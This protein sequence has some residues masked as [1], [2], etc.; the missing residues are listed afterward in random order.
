MSILIGALRDPIAIL[1]FACVIIYVTLLGKWM[2]NEVGR[3]FAIGYLVLVSGSTVWVLLAP[4]PDEAML[5]PVGE[6]V[7]KLALVTSEFALV[8]LAAFS[9]SRALLGGTRLTNF[10]PILG[11][12]ALGGASLLSALLANSPTFPR[13]A[14]VLPIIVIG[15]LLAGHQS[16]HVPVSLFIS[17][18]GGIMWA[19]LALAVIAPQW[20]FRGMTST[21]VAAFM[22]RL[23]GVT[24]HPNSLGGLAALALAI[25]LWPSVSGRV[26]CLV[27]PPTLAVLYL[28]ESKTAWVAAITAVLLSWVFRNS[29]SHRASFKSALLIVIVGMLGTLGILSIDAGI[30]SI[31]PKA[32]ESIT[33]LTGRTALWAT[34]LDLWLERPVLGYG[35][36]AWSESWRAQYGYTF[37]GQAHNQF[38]QALVQTGL[39]GLLV[40]VFY[41]AVLGVAAIRTATATNG[42]TLSIYAVLLLRCLTEAP[43]RF[44]AVDHSFLLHASVFLLIT[45][46]QVSTPLHLPAQKRTRRR[47]NDTAKVTAALSGCSLTTPR[48]ISTIAT[49]TPAGT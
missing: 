18:L 7:W 5:F 44:S 16:K 40:N 28:S 1:L 26:R 8:A 6:E 39:V 27:L 2:L 37:A 14:V 35:Q 13:S 31:D 12:S 3:T 41:L 11:L 22:A 49:I 46:A 32:V 45:L 33:T 10:L 17:S 48:P 9:I 29:K 42:A 20:A 15:L 24:S 21:A 36:D 34:S 25:S 43:L 30:A 38:V 4:R 23:A 19:S 47:R